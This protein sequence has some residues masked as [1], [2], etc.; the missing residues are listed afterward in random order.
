[1]KV[2]NSLNKCFCLT[3]KWFTIDKRL[4]SVIREQRRKR[5]EIVWFGFSSPRGAFKLKTTLHR[6]GGV[7]MLMV[8]KSVFH[9][10][11]LVSH[12]DITK[13]M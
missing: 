12:F 7:L 6:R 8:D 11:N 13:I 4:Y 1:M 2:T 3:L 5:A 9:P 10:K